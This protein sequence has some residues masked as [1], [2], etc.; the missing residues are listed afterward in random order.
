M[1]APD[2]D[3]SPF[4]HRAPVLLP[5]AALAA[6]AA[7]A[8][9][10][11][12]ISLPLLVA[13]AV[14]GLAWRRRAGPCIAAC[15]AGLLAAIL[16]HDL[17][18]RPLAGLDR[19]RPVE[20][21]G[22]VCGHW[23]AD[24]EGWSAPLAVRSIRQ[25][26]AVL[27]PRL[28]VLVYL[29]GEEAPP[30]FGTRLRARGYL[31]RSAGF[32]NR[33]AS[34]PGPWR[35]RVKSRVL[36]AVEEGPGWLA[37][38]SGRLREWVERAA[39][40]AGSAGPGT[41]LA[42]AFVLGDATDL[43]E[44]WRR[45]LRVTGLS[46]LLSVSG[47]HVALVA[48]AVLLL[49]SWL[50][51]TARL[52]L[53][54]AAI[55]LYLLLVGPLPALV[56][57]AVMGLLAVAALLAERPPASANALGWAVI[58]LVLTRPETVLQPSFQLS[59]AATAGLL[60]LGPP[61][62]AR[63]TLLPGW[64]G[65]SLATTVAAQI[66]TLPLALPLF[67]L[68]TPAAPLANLLALPWAAV[69]LVACLVWT[70]LAVAW[71]AAAGWVLPALDLLALP[72]GLPGEASWT[73]HLGW[74][75]LASA[76]VAALAAVGVTLLLLRAR[77]RMAGALLLLIVVVWAGWRAVRSER[78]AE[79]IL[80][81]VGQGD[82]ILLRDGPRAMLVDGGGWRRGDLGGR[83]LL[84]ALLGEG[85]RSLDAIV[86]THPDRDHCRGLVD[87]TAY[88]AIRE[89]WM[90]PGWDPE[91]CAG[92]LLALPGLRPRFL[93]RGDSA[94]LGRW[95]LAVLH[96][97]RGETRGDDNERSLVLRA[98]VH[99]RSALLTGDLGAWGERRL[100]DLP[101]E[102]VRCDLLK[103]GHHGSRSSS[104]EDFLE[105]AAPRLALVSAG[106]GNVFRHPAP[107]TLERL[108]ERGARTLRTDRDGLLRV[109]IRE[110]GEL[111]IELPGSPR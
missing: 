66:A 36:M 23:T 33:V 84:P 58:L 102:L 81:D 76:P 69:A 16:T 95:R 73:A 38:L 86:L 10:L 72:L 34:P 89:V 29:P 28:E 15:A 45:G 4:F 7:L 92:E 70:G 48:G 62:A 47:V 64:L 105:V 79:V 57:A 51:R 101:P 93:S 44:V 49:G 32:A 37:R 11:T 2:L 90:S 100:L 108:A 41:A 18:G 78:G 46:H 56:R 1:N 99:G 74:P 97:E 9:R 3:P 40:R 43:P 19:G 30:P 21:S 61:L 52:L 14:L 13:L 50:P 22:R 109:M 71:P 75:L 5:A 59:V 68:L 26:E 98:E 106:P 85:L 6:G 91:S 65:R 63:W 55:A 53:A 17:P 24:D 87:L 88:I 107:E 25:G 82:A 31:A 67:H 8:F 27:T 35:L 110:D 111:R 83:V 104:T 20:V 80:I 60:L 54:A 96:P 77:P 42:R 103:V 12:S 39:A 94:R